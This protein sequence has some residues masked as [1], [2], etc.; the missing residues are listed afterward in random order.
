[1]RA[2]IDVPNPGHRLK[3]GTFANA[4]IATASGK[5]GSVLS[6]PSSAIF[7][8]EGKKSV[9]VGLGDNR[10]SVI[11]VEVGEVSADD[12]QIVDV[13]GHYGLLG[14][15]GPRAW[16]AVARL[17]LPLAKT[18]APLAWASANDA[19]LGEV[20]CMKSPHIGG[21][22]FDLFV[23][24]AA[25]AALADK[26]IAAARQLGGGPC[27]WCGGSGGGRGCAR[28]WRCGARGR[29][30]GAGGGGESPRRRWRQEEV[31]LS[32]G[33]PR[34]AALCRPRQSRREIRA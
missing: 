33:M 9:F 1:M 8:I 11:P 7:E 24:S 30:Q 15:S 31:M 21:S 10:F 5:G 6:V 29:C 14:V 20:Y 12:V 27:G 3:P 2:R 32:R 34:H 28:G 19:T 26:L 4:E 22:G 23:P 16:D 13:S 17:G 25:L 18:L